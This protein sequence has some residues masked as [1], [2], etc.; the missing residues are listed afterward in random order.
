MEDSSTSKIFVEHLNA[1]LS[2]VIS[3]QLSSTD[4]YTRLIDVTPLVDFFECFISLAFMCLKYG[5]MSTVKQCIDT[6]RN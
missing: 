2:Y 6:W 5:K 3:F 4:F 1:F